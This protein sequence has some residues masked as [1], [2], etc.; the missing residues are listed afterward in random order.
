M[1]QIA[2]DAVYAF[3]ISIIPGGGAR[4]CGDHTSA[5]GASRLLMRSLFVCRCLC[6]STTSW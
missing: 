6:A 2:D 5:D 1:A 3:G 4:V